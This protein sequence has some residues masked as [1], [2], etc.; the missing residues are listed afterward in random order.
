VG[1]SVGSLCSSGDG[2]GDHALELYTA[3]TQVLVVGDRARTARS[4][5]QRLVSRLKPLKPLL[6]EIRES[7]LL[8]FS[9][10]IAGFG[11]LE[12]GLTKAKEL[13]EL[14]GGNGSHLYMVT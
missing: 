14:C 11:S 13:L 4:S 7:K 2:S 12:N 9:G 8:P 6:E 5:C 3:Y 1:G 10:A